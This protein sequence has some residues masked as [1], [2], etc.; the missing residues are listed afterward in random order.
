[1]CQLVPHHPVQAI[2]LVTILTEISVT[3][4]MAYMIAVTLYFMP[5]ACHSEPAIHKDERTFHSDHNDLEHFLHERPHNT[6]VH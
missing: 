5:A 6:K 2:S 1:M 4:H 3:D